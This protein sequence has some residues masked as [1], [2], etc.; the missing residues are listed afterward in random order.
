MKRIIS[1]LTAVFLTA[2]IASAVT[3]TNLYNFSLDA[4]NNGSPNVAT[5]GD[6][7][8]PDGFVIVG[9]VMYGTATTGGASG[10][11]TI[12]RVNLDGTHFTNLFNFNNG[13]YNSANSTYPDSTGEYVNPGLLLIS[14]TLYGTTFEGGLNFA[15]EVFKINLDGSGFSVIHSFD[16]TDGQGPS[17]GL[18]LYGNVLYGTTSGGG[19][20]TYGTVFAVNLNDLSFSDVYSFTNPTAPYGGVVAISNN[21]YGFAY[22]GGAYL[23]GYV[24][25][26]GSSGYADLFDFDGTNGGP[27]YAT[28]VA[29]GNTLYGATI[30]GGTNGS[31][32]IF[33][34]N[35]DGS[36]FTN[37]YNFSPADGAN[38]DGA[39]P[40]DMGGMILSGN[41][42]IGTTSAHGS[43]GQGTAFRLKT[44]GTG[45]TVLH[46]FQFSD[47]SQPDAL[48][49]SGGTLYGATDYGIQGTYLGNGGVFALILQPTLNLAQGR[50]NIVL[51]WIGSSYSLYAAP[52]V[53][54]T[55]TKIT[56]ATSPYTNTITGTQ[57]YFKL[58]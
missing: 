37:L 27:S 54:G 33:R 40:D 16:F 56:G 22:Y 38:T 45:F 28:P 51:S 1:I 34:I 30:D 9:N 8:S 7:I 25:R 36:A 52:T 24:Y 58:E 43:G 29:S 57:K 50:T 10:D 55:F 26:A 20:D 2:T 47:G 21:F 32:N 11:G 14:N 46:S 17:S 13:P 23:K 48:V 15:G 31:G 6:G 49:L 4:F 41:T 42:L 53:N 19:M 18:T 35:T 5:N 39:Q 3:F 44:D 12:F